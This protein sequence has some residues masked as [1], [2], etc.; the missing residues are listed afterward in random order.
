METPWLCRPT[1]GMDW[2]RIDVVVHLWQ[3]FPL[4]FL[5]DLLTQSPRIFFYFSFFFHRRMFWKMRFIADDFWCYT[6]KGHKYTKFIENCRCMV[7][8][9][10]QFKFKEYDR[11]VWVWGWLCIRQDV[12]SWCWKCVCAAIDVANT[13]ILSK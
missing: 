2:F 11:W 12:H 9:C 4:S 6:H 8:W 3:R 7:S 13:Y 10:R 5:M 1:N